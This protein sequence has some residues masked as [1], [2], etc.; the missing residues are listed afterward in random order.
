MLA[1]LRVVALDVGW[2]IL[3]ARLVVTRLVTGQHDDNPVD[4]DRRR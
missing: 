2:H 3:D 1:G 4:D